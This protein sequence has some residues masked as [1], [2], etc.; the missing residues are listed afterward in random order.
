MKI[1]LLVDWLVGWL[2]GQIVDFY[3][4]DD[5]ISM[6]RASKAPRPAFFIVLWKVRKESKGVPW[7][8]IP[9]QM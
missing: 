1:K 2:V 8:H 5:F 4:P 7:P 9:V 3:S 6:A